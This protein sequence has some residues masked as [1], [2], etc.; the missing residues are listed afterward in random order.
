MYIL[1][2]GR[3][4]LFRLNRYYTCYCQVFVVFNKITVSLSNDA[5]PG[6][7][8]KL[9]NN[10]SQTH[11]VDARKTTENDR[12]QCH[13]GATRHPSTKI[14]LSRPA[15]GTGRLDQ[16]N[17]MRFITAELLSHFADVGIPENPTSYAS[18]LI[19]VAIKIVNSNKLLFF[20][21]PK[22]CRRTCSGV[23]SLPDPSFTSSG[24]LPL[25]ATR[26]PCPYSTA[27]KTLVFFF[28]FF[29]TPSPSPVDWT[30]STA[31]TTNTDRE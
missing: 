31:T 15:A 19:I 18:A 6:R 25:F 14:L 28:S 2:V 11:Q 21:S 4:K 23:F 22:R 17:G 20:G 10:P 12:E 16:S 27:E 1:D 9:K 5:G 29:F 13:R 26:L 30:F 3:S 7:S 24:I 8:S